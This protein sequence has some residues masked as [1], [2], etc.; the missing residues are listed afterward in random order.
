[1]ELWIVSSGLMLI[2]IRRLIKRDSLYKS[3]KIRELTAFYLILKFAVYM[4]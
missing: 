2:H 1:M 4:G 3:Q